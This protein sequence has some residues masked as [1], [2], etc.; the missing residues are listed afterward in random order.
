MGSVAGLNYSL[1]FTDNLSLSVGG[2]SEKL[3][4]LLNRILQHIVQ[5]LSEVEESAGVDL[6]SLGDRGQELLMKL[7]MQRQVLLQDYGNLTREEPISVC[8]Y[9]ASQL[10]L[11]GSWNLSEYCKVLEQPPSLSVLGSAVRTAFAS[12]QLDMFVHGNATESDAKDTARQITDAFSV[13]G[14]GSAP[15]IPVREVIRLPNGRPTIFE[16]DLAAENPAQENNCTQTLYQVGVIGEDDQRDACVALVCHLASTSM[17]QRLRTEEQLGYIVQAGM[18]A[19]RHVCGLAAIVQGTKLA[20]QQVDERVEAW[21]QS[22]RADIEAMPELEFENNVRAVISERVQRYALLS[23]ETMRHW[24]EIQS[25]MYKFDRLPKHIT[26]LEAL[27][28]SEVLNFFDNYLAAG[29]PQ[30]R[31]LSVRVL[32]TSADGLQTE[33]AEGVLLSSWEDIRAFQ[34]QC[35]P[36]AKLS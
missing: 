30:R 2:F 7:D 6:E 19:E 17:Y 28:K 24:S 20:P 29:A 31:K 25:R 16:Y 22:F 34:A 23:Q 32:G 36:F 21:M 33:A 4:E 26:G 14:V 5:V 27:Q 12:L 10:M 13:L 15:A 18:W 8:N 1:E 3:P 35:L 11:N 9:Y